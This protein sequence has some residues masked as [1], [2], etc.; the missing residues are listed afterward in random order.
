MPGSCVEIILA[1]WGDVHVS[2]LYVE[3]TLILALQPSSSPGPDRITSTPACFESLQTSWQVQC[4]PEIWW[5]NLHI[6]EGWPTF[7]V[8]LQT[9]Q[10]DSCSVLIHQIDL[11]W[12]SAQALCWF[13]APPQCT[14]WIHVKK[15][16]FLPQLFEV[17][18]DWIAAINDS[19]AMDVAYLN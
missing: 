3:T 13:R 2:P 18:E 15:I 1:L 12:L 19:N 8:Q 6:Q 14:A 9:G 7:P 16:L 17:M 5:E 4:W 11:P 10:T